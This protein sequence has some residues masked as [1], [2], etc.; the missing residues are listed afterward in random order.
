MSFSYSG[1]PAASK[2]DEC[3]FLLSDTDEN[4]PI[5]Q[6]EEINFIISNVGDNDNLLKYTL[7]K[8]AA[9]IFS[10]AIKRSLGPQSEDPTSRLQYFQAQAAE[11]KSKLSAK[12]V[13]LPK[14]AHPKVFHRGMHNNPPHEGLKGGGYNV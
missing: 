12:G 8:Q 11:Y 5:L 1:N 13:S 3:R 6:D 4:N 14:Y 2:L 10:R 9:T 7:F